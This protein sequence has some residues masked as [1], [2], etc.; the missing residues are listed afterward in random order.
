MPRNSCA[1][2]PSRRREIGVDPSLAEQIAQPT[3]AVST[4]PSAI[5]PTRC[6]SGISTPKILAAETRSLV[7]EPSWP[8]A[9][10]DGAYG[11]FLDQLEVYGFLKAVDQFDLVWFT[12]E[13]TEA[14]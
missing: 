1:T 5:P 8:G 7:A 12:P 10:K 6:F 9:T 4:R 11:P 2:G 14:S 13:F 3:C